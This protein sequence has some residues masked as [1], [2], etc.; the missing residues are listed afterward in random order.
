M[1]TIQSCA[2]KDVAEAAL[3]QNKP[4]AG[5]EQLGKD[6]SQLFEN[7]VGDANRMQKSQSKLIW[8]LWGV[9]AV[10]MAVIYLVFD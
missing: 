7:L 10:C 1:N 5:I 9:L 3:N 6:F 2:L 8:S 4:K